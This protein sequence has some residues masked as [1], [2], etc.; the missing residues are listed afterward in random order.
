[1]LPVEVVSVARNPEVF[2]RAVTPEEGRRL[3]KITKTS[4]QPIRTRRAIVVMAS[5]QR[6]LV[7]AIARLMQVSEAYVRQVIHEFNERGFE[8]LDPK[9]SAGRPKKVDRATRERIACIARCCPRDLGWPFSVWSLSKLREVLL[10][11]GIADVSRE[12][13]RKILKAEGVSWQTTKTWKAGTDPEFTA[14]M[15]RVLD[16]YDHPPTDGRVVCVDEFGPLNLQP[17]TGRGWS[18]R[19]TPKRLPATYRRPQGV[20]H[21]LGALD[22]A[23]GKIHYRIRDR[24]RWQ[25]FLSLLKS[26]RARWPGQKLYVIID[27]FSPHKRAEV[28]TWA[29]ANDV[30]LVFLLTYSSWLNWIESEFA[31]LRYFALNGTDHRSHDEQDAAIGAYIRWYNQHARP[32]RDFAVNSKIRH[33]DYLPKVA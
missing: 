32:K 27:N 8:A 17:R 33:P 13:L 25:E 12:T 14:K 23:T 1:M 19:R 4:K 9:W 6:Q 7:P 29:A 31:A 11:N 22:L 5:A 28:R 21:L 18:P 15:N 20:R 24:K 10:S 26:L 2:V 30:E 16:L 3:Q